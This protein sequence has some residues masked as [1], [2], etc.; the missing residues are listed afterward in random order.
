MDSAKELNAIVNSTSHSRRTLDEMEK[1]MKTG[2]WVYVSDDSDE[3]AMVDGFRRIFIAKAGQN[4]LCLN[5]DVYGDKEADEKIFHR[6]C[7]N[8]RME[9]P[10]DIN[11]WMYAVPVPLE[12]W[13]KE[14]IIDGK[15]IEISLD[16]F[17]DLKRQLGC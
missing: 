8:D 2:D 14:I 3:G 12:D 16:V 15:K 6:L 13:K 1:E 9:L 11:K 7:D 5:N 4:F 10:V 17:E